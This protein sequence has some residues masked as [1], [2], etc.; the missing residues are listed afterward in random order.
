[1]SPDAWVC[2]EVALLI[3]FVLRVV[4]EVDWHRGH[5]FSDD[6]F[7]HGVLHWLPVLVEGVDCAAET[8]TLDFPRAHRQDWATRDESRADISATTDGCQPDVWL[9]MLID[10]L[11][12]L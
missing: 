1:M 12:S 2:L 8:A 5:W 9:D 11:E 4:P 7:T 10:P 6:Q 3:A